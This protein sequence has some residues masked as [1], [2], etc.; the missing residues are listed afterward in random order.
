[1]LNTKVESHSKCFACGQ[2]NK[3]GLQLQFQEDCGNRAFCECTISAE[4]QGYPGIVQ[5][6]I[7]AVI[8]DSAMTNCLFFRSVEAMTVR[9]NIRYE[10]PVYTDI[11]LRAVAGL[12]ASR[13]NVYDLEAEIEQDGKT[14]ATASAKF[15][16][17]R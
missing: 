9:L 3:D 6:G 11:P 17:V 15:M 5:G 4:Y 10:N 16:T 2:Q 12:I 14:K 1:M 7:V 13:K 8:L